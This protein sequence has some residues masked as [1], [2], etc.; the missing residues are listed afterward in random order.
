MK[1]ESNEDFKSENGN[2]HACGHDMHTAMLLTAARM[3][4]ETE[5]EL[6]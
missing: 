6:K 4:K 3:L 2:A 1:E 5:T